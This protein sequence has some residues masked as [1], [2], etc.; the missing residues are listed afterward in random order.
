[1]L[2][3]FLTRH[4]TSRWYVGPTVNSKISSI[5]LGGE[6][7]LRGGS[8]VFCVLLRKIYCE[9]KELKWFEVVVQYLFETWKPQ[10]SGRLTLS[11]LFIAQGQCPLESFPVYYVR[12]VVSCWF[13]FIFWFLFLIFF[14]A[15]NYGLSVCETLQYNSGIVV[16]FT[17]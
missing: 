6:L 17:V 12:T 16:L 7:S 2:F 9:K 11:G 15:V 4:K 1:M 5:I 8:G 10:V 3:K 13:N 14:W